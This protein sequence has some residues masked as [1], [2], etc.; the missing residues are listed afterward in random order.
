M[1]AAKVGTLLFVTSLV[2]GC[3][4]GGGS[5][6]ADP[7]SFTLAVSATVQ[8]RQGGTATVLVEAT[9]VAP[10]TGAID[11]SLSS[12]PSAVGATTATI[13]AGSTSTSIT[14]TA[15]ASAV[16]GESTVTA[17]GVDE[18]GTLTDSATFPLLV[19]GVPGAMDTT[20][21]DGE[22]AIGTS[23]DFAFGL[24][25]QAD[26]KTVVVGSTT[27]T[28]LDMLV[29]RFSAD[30]TPDA[31][32]AM[33]G[34]LVLDLGGDDQAFGV[35]VL[36]DGSILVCGSSAGE[37]AVARLTATGAPDLTF[38]GGGDGFVLIPFTANADI[39]FA[40]DVLPSGKI[41]LAGLA[42]NGGNNDFG[43]A[44]LH[45]QGGLDTTFNGSGR[46]IRD[47]FAGN[48]I[49]RSVIAL[50]DGTILVAGNGVESANADFMMIKLSATGVEDVNFGTGGI[51]RADFGGATESLF[52]AAVQADGKILAGG[53]GGS[54]FD[55]ALARFTAAGDP[56]TTWA[57]DGTL[58]VDLTATSSIRAIGLG[59]D[60]SVVV[61]GDAGLG[62]ANEF[63]F[64]RFNASGVADPTFGTA[65]LTQVDLGTAGSG[66]F[67]GALTGDGRFV[68]AGSASNGTDSDVGV[69]RIWL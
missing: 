46:L 1:K 67:A 40:M 16:Q 26:G 31:S 39:A 66:A 58:L 52:T 9:R 29:M 50:A 68:A 53:Q 12:L 15:E 25:M 55:W 17:T 34:R 3:S 41:L 11:V 64:G 33:D 10:F 20:W 42:N 69:A 2:A 21:S 47:F 63:T 35:R 27:T 22:T 54:T 45:A 32:F 37:M 49:A 61:A 38:G 14:V 19:K 30:G 4:G 18:T 51:A 62:S 8:V 24:A 65:G 23:D 6:P 5:D 28:D 59:T 57:T 56:D 7:G 44:K 43:V 48:D 60:G 36:A 13:P